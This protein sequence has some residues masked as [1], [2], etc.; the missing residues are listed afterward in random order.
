M[1]FKPSLWEINSKNTEIQD[2][3][4]KLNII[5]ITIKKILNSSGKPYKS[6]SNFFN[7]PPPSTSLKVNMKSTLKFT[8]QSVSTLD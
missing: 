4:S 2:Q 3:Q 6:E 7:F 5:N 1:P 8:V